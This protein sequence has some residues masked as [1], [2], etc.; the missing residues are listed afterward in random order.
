M[1]NNLHAAI[2]WKSCF[3]IEKLAILAWLIRKQR[4]GIV[5]REILKF[6]NDAVKFKRLLV[7]TTK[8]LATP[9]LTYDV[10]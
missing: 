7:A 2:E 3:Q 1:I 10:P 6:Q 9:S 8:M 4:N 5:H